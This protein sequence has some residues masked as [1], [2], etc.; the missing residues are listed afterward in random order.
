MPVTLRPICR[1]AKP[2]GKIVGKVYNWL[3]EKIALT[4]VVRGI[5]GLFKTGTEPASV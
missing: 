3:K 2:N 5:A 1:L 4:I